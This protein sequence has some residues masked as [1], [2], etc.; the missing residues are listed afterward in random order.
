MIYPN[1]NAKIFTV[2]SITYIKNMV[3][4]NKDSLTPNE[5]SKYSVSR[6]ITYD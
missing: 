1:V 5:A 3:K 4:K 2:N 6:T